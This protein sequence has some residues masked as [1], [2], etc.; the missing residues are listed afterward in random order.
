VWQAEYYDNL[1]LQGQPVLV[2]EEAE[3]NHDWGAGSPAKSVPTDN[4]SARWRQEVRTMAGTYRFFLDVDDGVRLWVDGLLL[5]DEWHEA[6]G[7]VY[8]TEVDLPEGVHRLEIEYY[9]ATFEA[10]I[11]FWKE[12]VPN[13][14]STSP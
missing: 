7:D 4:F 13:P 9:E 10:R 14:S 8:Q 2:R 5:I 11:H 12:M 1:S 6:T 3:L